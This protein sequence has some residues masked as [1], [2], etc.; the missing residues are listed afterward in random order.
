MQ[1]LLDANLAPGLALQ[2]TSAGYDCIHMGDVLPV[3]ATDPDIARLANRLGVVLITKDADF[4]DL[5]LRDVLQV[6]LVWMRTGNMS[7]RQLSGILLPKLPRIA[8]AI[9]AGERIIEIR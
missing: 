5:R 9:A 6:P 3:N 4:Y 7:N 8:S 2:I 1:F